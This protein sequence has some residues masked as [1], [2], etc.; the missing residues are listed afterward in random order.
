MPAGERAGELAGE[1]AGERAG[2]QAQDTPYPLQS[3]VRH[4]RFGDG[5]VMDYETDPDRVT[6]LFEEVGYRTLALAAVQASGLL[7]PV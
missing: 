1:R 2:E 3:R 6:V 5:V 7:T 4:P